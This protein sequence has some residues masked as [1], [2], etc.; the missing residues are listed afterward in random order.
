MGNNGQNTPVALTH[1]RDG[2]LQN[3]ERVL[4][5]I[6]DRLHVRIQLLVQ[7]MVKKTVVIVAKFRLGW[8][9]GH[10]RLST[11]GREHRTSVDRFARVVRRVGDSLCIVDAG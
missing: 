4:R 2:E 1:S 5:N 7:Y 3:V 8:G 11:L 6:A 10:Q 9:N